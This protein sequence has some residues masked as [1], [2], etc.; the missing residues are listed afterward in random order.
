MNYEY[1]IRAGVAVNP[2]IAGYGTLKGDTTPLS[3]MAE[4][5]KKAANLVD[6]VGFDN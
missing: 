5:R 6:K 1:P 3:T 4:N 2:T